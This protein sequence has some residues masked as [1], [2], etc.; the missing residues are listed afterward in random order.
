M[1]PSECD[2]GAE[3]CESGR[4]D[5]LGKHASGQLDRGFESHPLRQLLLLEST[6]GEIPPSWMADTPNHTSCDPPALFCC[7]GLTVDG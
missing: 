6:D 7:I 2:I 5:M 3:R 1:P 4:I